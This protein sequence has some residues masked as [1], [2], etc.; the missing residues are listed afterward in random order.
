MVRCIHCKYAISGNGFCLGLLGSDQLW[1]LEARCRDMYSGKLHCD[2]Q[3]ATYGQ[4]MQR[5]MYATVCII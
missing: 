5:R 4:Y 3:S 1:R 2:D